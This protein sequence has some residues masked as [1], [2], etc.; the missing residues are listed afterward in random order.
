LLCRR[1][2][3]GLGHFPSKGLL[4]SALAYMEEGADC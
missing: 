2:N 1:C 3:R 4:L